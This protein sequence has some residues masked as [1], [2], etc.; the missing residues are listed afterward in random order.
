MRI[1]L[2]GFMASGKTTVGKILSRA[3]DFDFFDIDKTIE[4]TEKKTIAEIFEMNG[5]KYFRKIE[6]E[7]LKDSLKKN[8]VVIAL[9][10][11]TPCFFDNI[12][13]INEISISFYLKTS[14]EK[15]LERLSIT[16]TKETR[17]LVKNFSS[18]NLLNFIDEKSEEREKFYLM[19]NHVINTEEKSKREIAAEI[20]SYIK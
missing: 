12:K 20:I 17:P 11:G 6:R 3:L 8:N 2:M 4:K 15:L 14:H 13:L 9:G 10:G 16:K 1:V 18:R 5:E 19:A 7:I